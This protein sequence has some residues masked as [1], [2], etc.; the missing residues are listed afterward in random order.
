MHS[1][2]V[3]DLNLVLVASAYFGLTNSPIMPFVLASCAAYCGSA[4]TSWLMLPGYGEKP[5]EGSF[6]SPSGETVARKSGSSWLYST[7]TVISRPVLAFL[8]RVMAPIASFALRGTASE[9]TSSFCFTLTP[10]VAGTTL[11]M[12]PFVSWKKT[13]CPYPASA[14]LFAS[15]L[16]CSSECTSPWPCGFIWSTYGESF[17][18]ARRASLSD[19]HATFSCFMRC[20]CSCLSPKLSFAA[21]TS[22]VAECVSSDVI[23]AS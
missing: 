8:R 14:Q 4:S 15:P 9:L 17:S 1:R 6:T 2:R 18:S 13:T 12:S 23:I 3:L 7:L 20:T 19:R 22:A 16:R 11:K 5:V 21:K 10:R